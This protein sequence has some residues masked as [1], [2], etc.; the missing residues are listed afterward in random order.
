MSPPVND[1]GT[2]IDIVGTHVRLFVL[3]NDTP[4]GESKAE[5][6]RVEVPKSFGR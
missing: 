1:P 5:H 4:Q 2:A 3:W 6:D